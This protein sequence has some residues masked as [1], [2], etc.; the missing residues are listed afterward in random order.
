MTDPDPHAS[1]LAHNRIAWDKWAQD[2]D[3]WTLPVSPAE[4]AAARAGEWVIYLTEEKPTPRDWFPADLR[5]V[6]V[7]CLASGGGQQG[8][9]LAAA[10]ANVTVFDNSPEQLA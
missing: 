2:G 3:R 9:I 8:P 1:I 7:L 4:V 6:D 10:G 5:G